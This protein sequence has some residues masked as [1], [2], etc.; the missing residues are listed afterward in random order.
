M[1]SVQDQWYVGLPIP[2]HKEK[3]G[4]VNEMLCPCEKDS[5]LDDGF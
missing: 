3:T 4:S 2:I 5:P 1:L